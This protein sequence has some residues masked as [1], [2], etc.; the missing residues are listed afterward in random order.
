MEKYALWRSIVA[1]KYWIQ[2]GGWSTNAP[3]KAYWTGVWH[4]IFK[5]LEW[6]WSRVSFIVNFGDSVRL[7]NHIWC[8]GVSLAESYP[9]IY[10][11]ISKKER[12]VL[13]HFSF[14]G[15]GRS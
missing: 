12:S 10:A 13:D 11:I 1:A 7:W 4:G 6:F 9:K 3:S 14:N 5:E 15:N 2:E 8:G